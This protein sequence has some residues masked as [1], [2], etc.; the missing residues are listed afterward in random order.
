MGD[1]GNERPGW[2]AKIIFALVVVTGMLILWLGVRGFQKEPD[3]PPRGSQMLPGQ[4][5]EASG[6]SPRPESP[7]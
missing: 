4:A 5:A 7:R 6:Q 2:V 1:R 3:G